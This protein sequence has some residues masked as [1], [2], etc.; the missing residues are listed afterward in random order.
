MTDLALGGKSGW[1]VGGVQTAGASLAARA[2][3]SRQNIEP[4]AR[5]AKPMP[6]S[7]RKVRRGKRPQW[8]PL[9]GQALT[10]AQNS[11]LGIRAASA[12]FRQFPDELKA[13][14]ILHAVPESCIPKVL[15]TERG[16]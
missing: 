12:E 2:T 16:V 4:S 1:P 7:A 15:V 13:A 8:Q 10:M 3:P 6:T 5:P 14:R 9:C 11:A